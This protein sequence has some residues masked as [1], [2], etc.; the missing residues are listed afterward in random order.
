V[1]AVV[2]LAAPTWIYQR[3]AYA[4]DGGSDW[5]QVSEY[6]GNNAK[7]GDG[8]YF[9]A[10]T[11]PSQRPRIA[12]HLYPGSYT[13]LVDVALRVPF[14]EGTWLWDAVIPLSQDFPALQDVHRLWVVDLDGSPDQKSGEEARILRDDGFTLQSTAH[15]HR[16]TVYEFTR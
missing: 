2:A 10:T 7:P 14:D 4:K 16:T 5:R 11:K 12:E 6:I 3:G 8:V 15:L 1:A 13:G 9:D